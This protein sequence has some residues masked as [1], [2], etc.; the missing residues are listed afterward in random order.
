VPAGNIRREAGKAFTDGVE[1]PD[2]KI[3]LLLG[4]KTV[5]EAL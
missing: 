2:T 3:P 4:E 5:T 1:D